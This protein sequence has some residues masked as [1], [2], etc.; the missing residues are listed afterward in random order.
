MSK[1]SASK[2]LSE[3]KSRDIFMPADWRVWPGAAPRYYMLCPP[4]QS[5]DEILTSQRI[6]RQKRGGWARFKDGEQSY[7]HVTEPVLVVSEIL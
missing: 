1:K 2:I 6:Q 3:V 4:G 5:K 7:F